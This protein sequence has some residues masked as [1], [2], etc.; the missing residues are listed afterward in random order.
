MSEETELYE[1]L[2]KKVD[3]FLIVTG[4]YFDEADEKRNVVQ[5]FLSR[6]YYCFNILMLTSHLICDFA[7]LALEHKTASLIELTYFI[8]CVTLSMLACAKS[9]LLVKNGNHVTDLIKSTK[10]L[11]AI[12]GRFELRIKTER[13]LKKRAMFLTV[14]MNLNVL[15]YILGLALF[16]IGPVILTCVLYNSSG[17]LVMQLPFLSWYPF[18]ETDIRYW[19]IAYLHQLWAGFIDATSVHGSDSFYSLSCTFLQI[20]FKT[21]QYD[22]EQIVPEATNI[23]TPE[24]YENFRKRLMPVVMRHQELIR[25]VNILEVI[26]SKSNLCIIAVSSIVICVSAFNLTTI[27]GFIW[28]TIFLAF[29]SMWLLQVFSLCYYSNLISLSSAEISN[30]VCN[31][32]W[33]KA[34]AQVMKDLLFVLKRAQKP[35][36]L[37]AWGYS[38]LNLAVFNKIVSKSWSYFALLQ[39]LNNQ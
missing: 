1:T 18:D 34:N 21:L 17:K 9:Y 33:Y 31:S 2:L 37:T 5:R 26:Y 15:L 6:R 35:C 32:L 23:N 19:P 28:K 27:D 29:L 8:P 7:W 25:C 38:D 14:Y 22:I 16:A 20:Q 4:C 10:K 13:E 36:K 24:L 11:Q 39:T 3:T 30:A 12:S